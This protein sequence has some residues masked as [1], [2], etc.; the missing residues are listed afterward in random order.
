MGCKN[1]PRPRHLPKASKLVRTRSKR[2]QSQE[3]PRNQGG[4]LPR[5]V[6][7]WQLTEPEAHNRPGADLAVAMLRVCLWV[8]FSRALLTSITYRISGTE[9]SM[10]LQTAKI[11]L[12]SAHQALN[13]CT[14]R[15]EQFCGALN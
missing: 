3:V 6:Q 15:F 13:G 14:E 12:A 11:I 7:Q 9:R 2:S 8:Q 10:A 1:R 4:R 5:Q